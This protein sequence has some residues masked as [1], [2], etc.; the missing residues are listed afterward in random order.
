MAVGG[1]GLATHSNGYGRL[2][3]VDNGG[4]RDLGLPFPIFC[5]SPTTCEV[6]GWQETGESN[7]GVGIVSN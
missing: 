4:V 6:E 2:W 7:V 3:L 5:T 1:A